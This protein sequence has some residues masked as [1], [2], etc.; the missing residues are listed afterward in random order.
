VPCGNLAAEAQGIG[1][2][3]ALL[4]DTGKLKGML[5]EVAGVLYAAGQQRAS[6]EPA[7][8]WTSR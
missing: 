4:V 6:R 2:G 3:S 5:S 7:L 1:P 8:S